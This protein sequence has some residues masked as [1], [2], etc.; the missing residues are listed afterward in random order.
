MK[1]ISKSQLKSRMLRIFRDLE[2]NGG[3]LIVTDH[4]RAVLKV[5]PIGPIRPSVTETFADVRGR[6]IYHRDL[7][8]PTAAE[9]SEI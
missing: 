4:G 8:E 2:K 5:S 9:W 1:T 7:L 6:A 3:E